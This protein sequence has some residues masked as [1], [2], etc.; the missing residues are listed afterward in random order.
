MGGWK[1]GVKWPAGFC[2]SAIDSFALLPYLPPPR[3]VGL[4]Q[5]LQL[6]V[7]RDKVLEGDQPAL[8]EGILERERSVEV[9]EGSI[10]QTD[11]A[12]RVGSCEIGRGQGGYV[13]PETMR[14]GE[15]EEGCEE[16][17]A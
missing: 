4:T 11:A 15:I 14:G 17:L 3:L 16:Q 2:T 5:M 13:E 1:E 9:G 10:H 8:G 6:A 12:E 7:A